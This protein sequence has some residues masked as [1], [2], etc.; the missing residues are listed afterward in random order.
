MEL[1]VC[2]LTAEVAA[3]PWRLRGTELGRIIEAR[4]DEANI[5][6]WPGPLETYVPVHDTGGFDR[7]RTPFGRFDHRLEQIKGTAGRLP[8][9]K[10]QVRISFDLAV[11]HRAVDFLFVHYDFDT[12]GLVDPLWVVSGDRLKDVCTRRDCPR[13]GTSHWDFIANPAPTARDRAAPFQVPAREIALRRWK[14]ATADLASLALSRLPLESGPFFERHFDAL[15]LESAEGEEVLA[16]PD[17]DVFGRDRIAVAKHTMRWASVAIKGA[18]ELVG[19]QSIEA[20]VRLATFRPHP[21]HYL[22][23]Q[24]YDRRR[25]AL[26]PWSWLVQST[27]FERLATRSGAHL[28]FRTTLRPIDNRWAPYRVPSAEVPVRFRTAIHAPSRVRRLG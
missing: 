3:E 14:Q 19:A 9:H 21:R 17:P 16:A 6:S 12:R 2:P 23:F 8:S 4:V 5:L 13:C 20:D 28:Q 10:D 1:N 7:I 26:H 22:L 24:Y 18:T 15:F 25:H 27:D 11:Q